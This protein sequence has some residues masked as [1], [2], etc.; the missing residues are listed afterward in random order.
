MKSVRFLL[1]AE[2]RARASGGGGSGGRERKFEKLS[3]TFRGKDVSS[4]GK[5]GVYRKSIVLG[6]NAGNSRRGC[7]ME[8]SWDRVC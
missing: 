1:T 5:L 7:R 3:R 4:K 6:N 8:L 2:S